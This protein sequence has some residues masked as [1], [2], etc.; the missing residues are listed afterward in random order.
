VANW[1]Q[2]I[3]R[4]FVET[5]E[6]TN[7]EALRLASEGEAGP[8]W[9]LAGRQTGGRGRQG[10]AWVDPRGN[11]AATLMQRLDVPPAEAA[12]RS[13]V[14]ALALH[15]ALVALSGE[16]ERFALKWPNDVLLDGGKLAGILLESTASS[17]SGVVLC[18]GIGVN[19]MAV[20]EGLEPGALPPVSLAGATGQRLEPDE[21]LDLLAPAFAGW[22]ARLREHGFDAVREAWL[23]RAAHLG[24]EIEARL[25]RACYRGVFETVD[26]TGALVLKT[27]DGIVHLPAADVYFDG[28][29]S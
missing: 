10:R 24:E 6:S 7:A 22:E 4:A 15:E 8:V 5:V 16:P 27:A 3:G 1:P 17:R 25:P 18:I 19:L 21:F 11:F 13:F 14:A 26:E 28:E 23:E 29:A 12:Q 20:P 2:G 9:I